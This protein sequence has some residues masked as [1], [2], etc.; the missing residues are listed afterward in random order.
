MAEKEIW[1][2]IE[3]YERY[4]VSNLG[5]VKNNKTGKIL[6]TRVASNGYLRVNLRKGNVKYEKPTVMH[7]HRLVAKAFIDNPDNKTTVNHIDGNKTNNRV[8][9]LEWA[10]SKENTAHAIQHGLMCPDY[11][12]MNK[13]SREASNAAHNTK[14]YR[15]KMQMINKAAGQ[16]KNVLQ[17]DMTSGTVLK[18]YI[19]CY[20]AARSL[21]GEGTRK[22]RLISRCARGKCRSAYGYIW[23]YKESE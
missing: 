18:E 16:T 1:K 7:V 20:E 19:N 14:A 23:R 9:N 4:T 2:D 3:G 8:D 10:T 11:S 13:K 22:D 21:F 17:I 6:S 5:N 12:G 15:K